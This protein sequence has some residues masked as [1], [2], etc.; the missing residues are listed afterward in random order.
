[1][2]RSVFSFL[3]YAQRVWLGVKDEDDDDDEHEAEAIHGHNV[4]SRNRR[5]YP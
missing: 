4:R 5:G 2:F 3:G 1:M